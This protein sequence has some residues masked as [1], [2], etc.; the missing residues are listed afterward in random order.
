MIIMLSLTLKKSNPS[1][2]WAYLLGYSFWITVINSELSFRLSA[3]PQLQMFWGTV[4]VQG[5][6]YSRIPGGNKQWTARPGALK[7]HTH[8]QNKEEREFFPL[9]LPASHWGLKRQMPAAGF[10]RHLT[11]RSEPLAPSKNRWK[12]AW[13][14]VLLWKNARK[15]ENV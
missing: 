7:D 6:N 2:F 15:K 8:P 4:C 11:V 10:T 12:T 1:L 3:A 13:I 9:L 14:N 5:F